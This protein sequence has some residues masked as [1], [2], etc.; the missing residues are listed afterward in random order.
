M[1]KEL[2]Q[3][4]SILEK[5][6][7]AV[8]KNYQNLTEEFKELSNEHQELKEKYD[9]ERKKNQVLAEEQKNIKLYSALSGNPDHNRLMKN[10]IN[11][12]IKEVDYCIAELQNNGL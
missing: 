11:R 4:F 6:V 12:L 8:S 1:L 5:K 2:E 9:E 10:H 7:L 3:N